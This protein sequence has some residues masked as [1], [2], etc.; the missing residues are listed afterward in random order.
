MI[1]LK[2]I[3][4]P[5]NYFLNI[6]AVAYFVS[7]ILI[8][9]ESIFIFL[10]NSKSVRNAAFSLATLFAGLWLTGVGLI[11]SSSSYAVA[12]IWSRYLS[13]MGIIFVT[14]SVFL[15][16]C[17][18]KGVISEKL[19]KFV[20]VNYLVAVAF[21]AICVSSNLLVDGL[22]S[23]WWG[24]YPKA[25]PLEAVFMAWFYTLMFLSFKNFITALKMESQPIKRKQI[26]LI[27]IAFMFGFIGSLDFV[28]NYGIPLYT[29]A[30]V[31]VLVFSTI[32]A[33]TI[34][35]YR[36]MEIETVIH[37]TIAWF[38]TSL[39]LIAPLAGVLFLTR[40][41]Y[42]GFNT[43]SAWSY[44]VAILLSFM[45][46]AKTF[47]PKIDH[48]FQRRRF[49][50]EKVLNKFSDELVHLKG[51]EELVDRISYTIIDTVYTGHVSIF[52][53]NN[54]LK[55]FTE[56]DSSR[57]LDKTNVQLDPENPFIEWLLTHD[58]IINYDF[59]EINPA[60]EQIKESAK[61]YF[62][63]INAH[64]CIPLVHDGQLLGL[65][66]LDRKLNLKPYSSVDLLF[67]TF[68]K[69]QS[70]IAISNSLAY[71][72]VEELV[73]VRTDELV[74]AQKQLI[75]AEKMAT[76]GTLAG[77][78]A[79]EIN[80]PLTAVL[81][82]VQMLL[83]SDT[84]KDVLDKE[85]LELIEEATK[86][87]RTIVKKLMTYARKPLETTAIEKTNLLD[88]LN[89]V[90]AFIGYQLEQDNIRIR[91]SAGKN[92]YWVM[93]SHNELEQVFTNLI[94]N[95]RDTIRK[96]K[97]AGAIDIAFSTSQNKITVEISDEGSGIPN[98]IAS[99][100][101]DPFFTTKDVGRGVGLGLSICHSIMEKHSG[102][103]SFE[104]EKGK[105]TVF[106]LELP[107]A[108]SISETK[109]VENEKK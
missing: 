54:R 89:N 107:E 9:A 102:K 31:I 4:D 22:W 2:Q 43:F 20:I 44:L 38:F 68:L 5:S 34:I 39:L 85:S 62:Q 99:K 48:I 69:N 92:A 98:E 81:T 83:A 59:L 57:P 11:Y 55:K 104:T 40:P 63:Q 84:I 65:I 28:T 8:L 97:K 51:I 108:T 100:I 33:Y 101:F 18:W 26:K 109:L 75:Q 27:I 16:S 10:Q 103:I 91:I 12:D 47:M 35:V 61:Q 7:G 13:W 67:L 96:V 3:F 106:T 46:F 52:L 17:A 76:V 36:F 6:H 74:Q 70:T 1:T 87:C 64:I 78:V 93:G 94:L 80:N 37:K 77:G 30:A 66:N 56:I 95:A 24:F 72:R 14:P 90:I 19:R 49:D 41:L 82:N 73:K 58:G 21:Q 105:G 60:F 53:R 79:H 25:G 45:F 88:V 71:D 32:V 23:F 50:L 29:F 42:V 15:F 86:R